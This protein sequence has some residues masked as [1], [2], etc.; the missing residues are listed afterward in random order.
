MAVPVEIETFPLFIGG[1]WTETGAKRTIRVP[2]DGQPA[3]EI[4]E[5]D[6]AVCD[7]AVAAA[8]A[9]ARAMRAMPAAERAALLMRLE[10]LLRRDAEA[11][12]ATVALESGKPIRDARLETERA[13]ATLQVSAA[14]AREL[15]GEVVP[16]EA[17]PS[18]KGRMAL[19]VREPLGII[20]AITP[21]NFPLN[22]SMHKIGPA[23]AAGNAVVHKPAGQ[24]PLCAA[25]FAR[26]AEEA[27]VPV[28]AYNLVAGPGGKLGRVLVEDARVAMVT[29]TGSVP[30]G[31]DIRARAG[32]KRV[33]LELGGN[34]GCIIEPDA[35]LAT[36]AAR[37]VPGAFG[38][39][40]QSC[41]S[42]QRVY[43]HQSKFDEY[44]DRFRAATEKMSIGHPLD[45]NS[46]ITSLITEEDAARVEGWIAE[47]VKAGARLVTGGERRLR[48]TVTPAILTD[49]PDP[50]RIS[51]HEVFGP[52]VA[53]NRY[54]DL[55][56]AI[57]RVNATPYGLQ[58]GIFT[59]DIERAFRAAR[60]LEAGG[61]MINDVPTYRADHMPYGGVKDSGTGRE[62]PRYAVEEMTEMKLI[63]W[64]V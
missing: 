33:T 22:L 38:L 45:E 48:A 39:S 30:V 50:V 16:M 49:V 35:D 52:V 36:A 62:G 51:C 10:A 17:W 44:L 23:L 34:A 25:R 55:D 5:A 11:F 46:D 42:L 57:R 54:S 19:T 29:F 53:V 6:A 24:T 56:D 32:F 18:G 37:S 28:G 7:R 12:A 64:K 47:A 4:F 27:G 59:Q 20:A 13:M 43:V 31:R 1:K 63:C 14:V 41:I 3:G 8:E 58:A 15:R 61:V 40:G 2:F 60:A 9:G 21:F 26:L